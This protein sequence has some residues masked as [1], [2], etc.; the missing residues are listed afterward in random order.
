MFRNI[1]LK[2][3]CSGASF[4]DIFLSF[5]L[6]NFTTIAGNCEDVELEGCKIDLCFGSRWTLA[7]DILARSDSQYRKE[8]VRH[9]LIT[10]SLCSGV[11]SW[12]SKGRLW[13]E[14]YIFH[15]AIQRLFQTLYRSRAFLLTLSL[16]RWDQMS[17]LRSCW[18]RA[19]NLIQPAGSVP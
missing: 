10:C 16:H 14:A 4:K 6:T 5:I 8:L 12:D 17:D 18:V 11:S 7:N 15:I 3:S 2:L 13:R 19:L 9:E 1:F